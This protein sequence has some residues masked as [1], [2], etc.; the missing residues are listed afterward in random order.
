ML[1]DLIGI[2]GHIC[3]FGALLLFNHTID[4][5]RWYRLNKISCSE[6]ASK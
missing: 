6:I 3:I 5:E 4:I 2:A 1:I